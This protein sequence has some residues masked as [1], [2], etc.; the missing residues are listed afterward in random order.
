MIVSNSN[1]R[2]IADAERAAARYRA[3]GYRVVIAEH[4]RERAGVIVQ[5]NCENRP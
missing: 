1:W 2:C 3:R 4:R 5:L